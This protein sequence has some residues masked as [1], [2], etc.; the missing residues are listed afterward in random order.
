MILY[1]SK[2]KAHVLEI[3]GQ[4]YNGVPKKSKSKLTLLQLL[5]S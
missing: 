5:Q 1:K 4:K 2:Y 3:S